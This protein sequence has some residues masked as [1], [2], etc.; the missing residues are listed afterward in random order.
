MQARKQNDSNNSEVETQETTICF[1]NAQDLLG[2]LNVLKEKLQ[3]V[4]MVK[5]SHISLLCTQLDNV[6]CIVTTNTLPEELT[7]CLNVSMC[8]FLLAV[9]EGSYKFVSHFV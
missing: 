4:A 9:L 3:G 2:T 6:A 7:G 1:S 5:R 8:D